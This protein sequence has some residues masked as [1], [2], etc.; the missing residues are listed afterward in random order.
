MTMDTIRYIYRIG[1][2]SKISARLASMLN[3]RP[4]NQLTRRHRGNG[5]PRAQPRGSHETHRG[6]GE[7]ENAGYNLTF[8]ISHGDAPDLAAKLTEKLKENF[9]CQDIII[10]DYSPI[11]GYGGGP[12]A[13]CI[14]FHPEVK[15]L[16]I[17]IAY[18]NR[19][20]MCSLQESR[21][22]S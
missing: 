7:G 8:M 6:T 18:Y 22:G 17:K 13:M 19:L 3:I 14:A 21:F 5:R 10:S 20:L 9:K 15:L 2:M 16:P 12:G 1:R 11:M 4:I